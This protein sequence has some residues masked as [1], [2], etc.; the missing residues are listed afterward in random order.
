[1]IEQDITNI[2]TCLFPFIGGVKILIKGLI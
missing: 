2:S 1:M